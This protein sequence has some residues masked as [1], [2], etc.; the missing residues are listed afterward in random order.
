MRTLKTCVTLLI[1]LSAQALSAQEATSSV[2]F[3]KPTMRW[4]WG[5]FGFHNSEATMSAIMTD[6]FRDQRVLKSFREISPTYSRVF[7]GYADW[8]KEAMDRFAD[9]YDATFRQAGTILYVVPGRMP[10]IT[11][12]FNIKDY[13][14][15]VAGN[16]EYLIKRRN[17]TGI[18]YYCATNELSVGYTYAWFSKH[19]DLYLR[20]NKE[21]QAAFLRH[22]LDIGLMTPDASG[23]E[24]LPEMKWAMENMNELTDT[25]CWHYYAA[26]MKPDAPELYDDLH[27]ALSGLVRDA[28][29]REKRVSLGEFGFAGKKVDYKHWQMRD[30]TH[31]SYRDADTDY[32]RITAISRLEMALAA[33][34]S[35]CISAVNWTF[36]DYPDPFLRENGDTPEAKARYDVARFSGFG[37]DIRYNKWGLFRWCDDDKDYSSYADLYTM[38]Y[39][40]K[41]FRK[42]GRVLPWTSEDSSLRCGGITNPDGSVSMVIINWGEGKEINVALPQESSK[43]FRIYE[44]DSANPPFNKFNDLQPSKGTVQAAD[45][46]LKVK[47]P[48][49]SVTFLTSDYVDR[50][51]SKVAGIRFRNG[52]LTWKPSKDREHVYYRIFKNGEQ[53]ASTVGTSLQIGVKGDFK[54][55]SVD[56]WGNT[57]A[58]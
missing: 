48:A 40:A 17:C 27:A 45:G 7:A 26:N 29:K 23:F 39:F 8:T 5:G 36:C 35:G 58:R 10:V 9:Y 32:T 46:S 30:D 1:I 6:E 33:L 54:V 37:L 57:A 20:I 22:G 11:E 31:Q 51:P 43:P 52:L 28:I 21:L 14:E 2:I 42:G 15:K 4:L 19:M 13:C 47:V 41:L 3:T 24:K 56:R 38:G 50:A 25:Y 16:L 53:I 18:R 12:D 55:I 34:N 49:R 44:Y